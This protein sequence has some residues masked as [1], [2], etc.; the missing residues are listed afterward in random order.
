MFMALTIL[1]E[2]FEGHQTHLVPESISIQKGKD[3]NPTGIGYVLFESR[4]AAVSAIADKGGEFLG[5]RY[6]QH[7]IS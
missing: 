4:E 1:R 3:W 2:F 5:S 7:R 6:E